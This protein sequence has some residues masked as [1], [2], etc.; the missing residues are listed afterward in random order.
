MHARLNRTSESDNHNT[1]FDQLK[2]ME[3]VKWQMA[4]DQQKVLAKSQAIVCL[5]QNRVVFC[6]PRRSGQYNLKAQEDFGPVPI[7]HQLEESARRRLRHCWWVSFFFFGRSPS[8]PDSSF[9]GIMDT[10]LGSNSSRSSR[11]TWP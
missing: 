10:S 11:R 9:G 6:F 1:L 2:F 5:F 8:S 3:F 7:H 4:H